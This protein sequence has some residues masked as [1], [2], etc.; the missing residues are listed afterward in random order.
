VP[1]PGVKIGLANIVTVFI[2][3]TLGWREAGAVLLVRIFLSSLIF[4]SFVSMLYS[5]S[6][7][8]LSFAVMLGIKKTDFFS[9]VGVSVFGGVFHNVG[10]IICA[11]FIL[12]TGTVIAY[13]PVLLISGII[14]GV[15]VGVL[16][17]LLTVKL[18]KILK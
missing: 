15:A 7:A 17:G 9:L 12:G 4:G 2:I 13:L 14:G 11:G 1:V 16:G 5:L 8:I 3:Y 10:Q 6:G 18:E